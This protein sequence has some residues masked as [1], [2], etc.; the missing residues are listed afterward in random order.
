MNTKTQY[1]T[2]ETVLRYFED[3][4]PAYWRI[5]YEYPDFIGV[6]HSAFISDEQFIFIGDTNGYFAFNDQGMDKVSGA[7]ENLYTPAEIFASF[8]KQIKEF[9]P[10]LVTSK[11]SSE[12]IK[13]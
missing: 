12:G 8:W 10:D 5:S 3:N 6:W 4:A 7:M 2:T 13:I 9:Y 1:P 11:N